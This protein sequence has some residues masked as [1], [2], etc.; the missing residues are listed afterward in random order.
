MS[1]Q[2]ICIIAFKPVRKTVHVLRQIDYLTPHYDLTIIG[3]GEPDPS[4]PPVTWHSVPGLTPPM[5]GQFL[6]G[7]GRTP[8]GGGKKIVSRSVRSLFHQVVR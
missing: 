2:R 8:R 5:Y 3:H 4:W 1:K 6:I 7:E